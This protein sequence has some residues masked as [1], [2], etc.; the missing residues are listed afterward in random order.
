MGADKIQW[1]HH[2]WWGCD[3]SEPHRWNRAA[4]GAGERHRVFCCASMADVFEDRPDLA[5][6]RARLA[7]LI[8]ET[9]ALDWLLITKRPENAA[10]LW[11][12]AW[13]ASWNGADSLGFEWANIWLGTTVESQAMADERIPHLLRVPARGHFLSCEPLLG[14]VNLHRWLCK[15]ATDNQMEQ[16]WMSSWCDPS[17]SISW[18]I[19]G[20][21]SGPKARPCAEEWIGDLVEQCLVAE[22]PAFVFPA[23]GAR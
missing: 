12:D 13:A 5:A 8:R 1:A 14:R 15:H 17:G 10:R 19:I 16:R 9:P 11:A 7:A 2:T 4:E 23:G 20:G 21:E 18:V 22:V 3:W 6:A